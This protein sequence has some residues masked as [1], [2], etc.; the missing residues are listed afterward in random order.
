MLIYNFYQLW[1]DSQKTVTYLLAGGGLILII[2]SLIWVGFRKPTSKRFDNLIGQK[3]PAVNS[4]YRR[5]AR[6]GLAII[7]MLTIVE[8]MLLD[9]HRASQKQKLII[10]I[11]SF[12]GPEEVYGLCNEIKKSLDGNF[13]GDKNI[14]II[15]IN[16]VVTLT[17]GSQ[18]ARQLGKNHMA[19]VVSGVGIALSRTQISI[20]ILKICHLN[21]FYLS[22]QARRCNLR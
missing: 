4:R 16:E 18:Y 9:Q 2:I 15:L 5:A 22:R 13:S 17:Q 19:D 10:V 1:L 3:L 21:S 6:V 7:F 11:A 20:S 14:E 8:G 12:E